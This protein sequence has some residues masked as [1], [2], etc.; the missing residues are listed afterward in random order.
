MSIIEHLYFEDFFNKMKHRFSPRACLFL[1]EYYENLSDAI[2]E[3]IVFDEIEIVQEWVEYTAKELLDSCSSRIA[4]VKGGYCTR[5]EALLSR[6][7]EDE[8]VDVHRM[9]NNPSTY[10]LRYYP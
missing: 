1:Y 9:D 2:E 4:D 7:D 3:D 5:M 10:L 8:N 6:L